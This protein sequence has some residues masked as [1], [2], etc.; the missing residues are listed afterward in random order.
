MGWSR[1]A[2]LGLDRFGIRDHDS[3]FMLYG[4]YLYDWIS[5]FGITIHD[6]MH[7]EVFG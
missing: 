3:R 4:S 6:I 1:G 5:D 2:F 7:D